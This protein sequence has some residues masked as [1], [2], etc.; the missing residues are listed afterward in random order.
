MY[1][2]NMGAMFIKILQNME[3]EILNQNL[4]ATVQS[5]LYMSYSM[6]LGSKGENLFFVE[7]YGL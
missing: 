1:L 7:E 3:N 5:V 2:S 4:E 6:I